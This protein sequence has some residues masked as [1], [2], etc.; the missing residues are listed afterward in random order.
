MQLYFASSLDWK[1]PLR[2]NHSFSLLALKKPTFLNLQ[3]QAYENETAIK[4]EFKKFH[5]LLQDEENTR[6]KALKLEE[7]TKTQIMRKK[8]ENISDQINTLSS[9]ISDIEKALKAQDIQLLRV[10]LLSLF[11]DCIYL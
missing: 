3:T 4:E 6:L 8:L 11:T 1:I 7:E 9:T 5:Q 10:Y 2:D